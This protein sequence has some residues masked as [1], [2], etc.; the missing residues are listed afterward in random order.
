MMSKTKS[1]RNIIVFEG[2]DFSGKSYAMDKVAKELSKKYT[3]ST[4]KFP[5]YEHKT[6]SPF[7]DIILNLLYSSIPI[8]E[9]KEKLYM[10]MNLQ[11]DDK[12]WG[13]SYIL[14]AARENDYLLIDRFYLSSYAY[15]LSHSLNIMSNLRHGTR[16]ENEV[17]KRF[18]E[19]RTLENV[20]IPNERS[21]FEYFDLIQ[22]IFLYQDGFSFLY[23][24]D[25]EYDLSKY[26]RHVYFD[27]QMSENFLKLINNN[28]RTKDINDKNTKLQD[29][30]EICYRR[31]IE[32]LKRDEMRYPSNSFYTVQMD[33]YLE[34][35][36]PEIAA[37]IR[38]AMS[39][40]EPGVKVFQDVETIK[41][42]FVTKITNEY[43]KD[44][45]KYIVK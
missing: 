45:C 29:Q 39:K 8:F 1:N 28:E 7:S 34:T 37:D 33:K 35:H 19:L 10:F 17:Y 40:A 27:K 32:L 4:L 12:R 31:I 25:I 24:T 44:I 9:S 3:I 5:D 13:Q 16:L 11:I 2:G 6:K 30:V 41:N 23:S 22:E 42:T 43:V 38:I 36:V 21:I 18:P 15:D 20:E 26:I 14:D